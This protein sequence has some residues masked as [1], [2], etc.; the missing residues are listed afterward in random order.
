MSGNSLDN[1]KDLYKKINYQFQN[2]LFLQQA[3]THRSA[4]QTNNE[5]FEFLGDAIL[6]FVV[7]NT[8]FTMFPKH[9]EGE[10]SRLRALLVKGETLTEIAIELNLSNYL[11]LG[12]GE[13]KSGGYNRASILANALEAIFAAVFFD[14]GF[15]ASEQTILGLYNTRLADQKLQINLK[16][17]KTQLQEYLQ[18]LKKPLPQYKL[19]KI[20]GQEHEQIFYVSCK[21]SGLGHS[22]VSAGTSRRKAEQLAAKLTFEKLKKL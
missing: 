18:S 2:P 12:Q 11:I 16:D 8:L 1:L 9:S 14:G 5:R 10:L 15:A 17:P 3:L 6:N 4:G 22:V 20:C 7:A 19:V 21:V 13:S